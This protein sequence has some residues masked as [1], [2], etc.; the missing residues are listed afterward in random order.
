[1]TAFPHVQAVSGHF[2]EVIDIA[3]VGYG[4]A[5]GMTAIAASKAGRQPIIFEKMSIPGGLSIC[6]GGGFRIATDQAKAYEY[7]KAT[8]AQTI[9][10]SLLSHFSGEMVKLPA[11]LKELGKV[12]NASLSI[13]DRPAN[14]PL[15]GYEAFQFMEYDSIPGFDQRKEF[16]RAKSLKSGAN[17]FKVINDNVKKC[18]LV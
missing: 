5:G 14:Y 16:P 9:N 7:L 18:S 2:D 6:S 8:N 17:A 13:I 1:M 15:P 11:L 4:F 12:N 3:I 10:E